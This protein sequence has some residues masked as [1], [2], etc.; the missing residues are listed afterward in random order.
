MQQEE[1]QLSSSQKRVIPP[2]NI[3]R[4]EPVVPSSK[5]YTLRYLLAATCAEG[6]SSIAFPAESDDSDA[7]FRGCRALG[8][9]LTWENEQHSS[10][11]VQSI[12][13]SRQTEPV[14]VNVGNAG[15]VLR[16]LLGIG[17]VLPEI[18]F[19]TDHPRSLGKRP[20]RELLEALTTLGVVCEGTDTEGY[21]PI[22]LRGS[23]IHG[24][25]VKISGARS[26]Q[27]LS[28]LLYL[29]PLIGEALEIEVVD[30][31]KS[32]PLVHATL[33]V[34]HEAGILVEHDKTLTHFAIAA[35]Q[36]YVPRTY[37]VPG[38]YPSA[39]TWLAACAVSNNPSSEIQLAR[40][41]HGDEVGEEVL[42][43][44]RAMGADLH[45]VEDTIRIRG[46]QRL[47]GITVDGDRM[48][49]CIPALVAAACFAEGESVF[50]NIESL[51]YKESDR[52]EDL[53]AELRRAGC[54][55][56]PKRD[57]IIVQ[58]SPQ[59]IE[60]GVTVYGHNDH[61]VL[62]ALAIVATRS[63]HGL[64]LTGTE[65]IS[66]SYPRFFEELQRMSIG[67]M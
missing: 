48:I 62:M 65:H 33:E 29:A 63:R 55:V 19:V 64:T 17:A 13:R 32:Q 10:L 34:L 21:L 66:K 57:A 67:G 27:Y 11:S 49:D 28:A 18:T 47:H 45:H 35:G 44:F 59:S 30:G 7:L 12:G 36:H 1:Q 43:A 3:L 6:E 41:R 9:R 8:A 14:T 60:G 20:N 50:Y 40:L 51:H 52:I 25:H 56:T 5:Y 2:T 53:C 24:G 39:A 61:R 46:G 37:T 4:G 15:A 42:A 26:S 58:G 23:D 38:D 16:L 22:T 31:L 54:I